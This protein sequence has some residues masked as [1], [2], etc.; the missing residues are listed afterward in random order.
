MSQLKE[1]P[2]QLSIQSYVMNF[3]YTLST[4]NPNNRWMEEM[5][6]EELTINKKKAYNQWMD[7]YTTLASGSVVN[8]LPSE[9][10]FQDLTYVANMGIHLPHIKDKNLIVLSNFTSPPRVGEELV[11]KK[12]FEM[13]G[14]ETIISP[15]KFEGEADLKY[16]R[17]NVYIGGWGQRTDPETYDWMVENLGMEILDLEMVDDYLYH[18]DCTVFPITSESVIM[19]SEMYDEKE[20]KQIEKYAEIIDINEDD[21]MGGLTNSVRM[22]NLILCGSNIHE[23][24]KNSEDYPYEKDKI[25]TLEKICADFGMEPILVN[26]SE[27]L[28][29]GAML[30]C[31]VFHTN[32]VSQLKPLI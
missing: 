16:L 28:K 9:G 31:L 25:N 3:P 4:T 10:N 2:S 6:P 22:G 14:Y 5:K 20:I 17:D 15:H 27:Y 18:L 12:Y 32:R 29:S 7:L 1:T 11:G 24:K 13:M 26:L 8:L 19:C 21:A 30:S 23:L